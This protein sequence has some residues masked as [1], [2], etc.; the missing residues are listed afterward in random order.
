M[1]KPDLS[2]VSFPILCPTCGEKFFKSVGQLIDNPDFA[3]LFC[4]SLMNISDDEAASSRLKEFI[5]FWNHAYIP[6]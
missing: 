5:D 1:N 4:N 2:F 6:K 3:C